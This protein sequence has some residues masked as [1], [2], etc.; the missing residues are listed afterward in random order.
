MV[1]TVEKQVDTNALPSPDQDFSMSKNHLNTKLGEM[2]FRW[3]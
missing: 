1:P 3:S 2:V